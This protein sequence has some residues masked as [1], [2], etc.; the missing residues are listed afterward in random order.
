MGAEV[1]AI[2]HSPKKEADAKALG[3]KGFISTNPEGW[4][5]PWKYSFDMILNTT[6]A[7]D[8]FDM[9][10]YFSTLKINGTFHTVGI[11]DNGFPPL[12][13]Q[14]LMGTGCSISASHIGSR[15][16]VQEMLRLA[17][18]QNIKS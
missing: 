7:T 17:S 2:S 12:K 11:S 6:D 8:R 10:A 4:N 3:A 1:Y 16:E 18:S 13:T 5:E 15:E 9:G 14:D